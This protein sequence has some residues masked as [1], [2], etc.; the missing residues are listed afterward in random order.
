MAIA[1]FVLADCQLSNYEEHDQKTPKYANYTFYST[2]ALLCAERTTN[3]AIDDALERNKLMGRMRHIVTNEDN[4]PS[5]Y[6]N[7][8]ASVIN[9]LARSL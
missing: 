5:R 4:V 7:V 1:Y 6:D 8:L 2:T 9:Q 3:I